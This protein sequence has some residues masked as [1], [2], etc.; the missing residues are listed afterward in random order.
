M[1]EK[2]NWNLGISVHATRCRHN[3]V[4]VPIPIEYEREKYGEIEG[5]YK[6]QIR[7]R[8]WVYSVISCFG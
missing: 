4:T 2:T 3:V 1:L 5:D 8:Y 7:D 6:E